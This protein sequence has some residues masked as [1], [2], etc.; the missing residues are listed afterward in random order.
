MNPVLRNVLSRLKGVKP[1]GDGYKAHC[2]C[3]HHDDQRQS[4]SVSEGE[5]GRVLLFCHAGCSVNDICAAIGLE[6]KDLYP[7]PEGKRNHAGPGEIIATYDYKD[8]TGKLLFQVCRTA[9]KKFF[10]RRPDGNGGWVNGLGNIKPVLYKLPELLQAV[11]RGETVFI[12]EGEKDCDNL[13]RLGL[14]A[15]TNPMGAGKW[16]DYYSDWLKGANCVILPDNDEPGRKH[17][18]QVARSLH[19]KAASI[20]VLELPGLPQK[21]DVSDWLASGGTKEELLR[22]I[23][24]TPEWE[25]S[26]KKQKKGKEEDDRKTR[27]TSFLANERILLEQIY[28]GKSMFLAFDTATGEAK[29]IP[30][31]EFEDELIEPI[32]GED[33]ELGA[34]KLPSG[35]C[36]YGDTLTLLAEIETHIHKYLDVSPSYL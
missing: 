25:P 31:L 27:Q 22:L 19:G 2:P 5:D 20:K 1:C 34:V 9:G 21:G 23:A 26:R 10:Q 4:L 16:R 13:S 28:D 30:S 33:I 24:E 17:A 6:V 36:E 15:T 14:A 32:N 29:T 12:P 11:Q 18:E 35:V 8:T 7:K 3:P